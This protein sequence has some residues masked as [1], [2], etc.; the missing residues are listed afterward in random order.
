[1][2]LLTFTLLIAVVITVYIDLIQ[3]AGRKLSPASFA[4]LLTSLLV[5]TQV[6][7]LTYNTA[8]TASNQRCQA[9]TS[10]GESTAKDDLQNYQ[11]RLWAQKMNFGTIFL[12]FR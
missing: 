10:A 4:Y 6:A 11:M 3:L 2:N 1:M 5:R 7:E 9:A 8:E 12:I